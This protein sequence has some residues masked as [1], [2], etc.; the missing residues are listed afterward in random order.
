MEIDYKLSLDIE[1]LQ[2]LDHHSILNILNVVVYELVVLSERLGSVE[3]MDLLLDQVQ[4]AAVLITEGNTPGEFSHYLN[5]LKDA[6]LDTV[7]KLAEDRKIDDTSFIKDSFFNLR[8]IFDILDLRMKELN[9]RKAHPLAWEY[10]EVSTLNDNMLQVFEA[11]SRNSKGRYGFVYDVSHKTAN[12]YLVTLKII[13]SDPLRILMPPVFQDVVRDL[14]ANSRKYTPIGGVLDIEI[15][16]NEQMF[17]FRVTD[18]GV[19]IPAEDIP[20]VIKFGYRGSN[21]L[22]KRTMG[23]GFGLTKAYYMVHLFGG[24]MWIDSPVEDGMGTSIR[25]QIPVPKSDLNG[26]NSFSTLGIRC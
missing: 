1:Q 21:V 11:I 13:S 20:D 14:A 19:G 5:E 18:T 15:N 26:T 3:E 25:V 6:I 9:H 8:S 10:M 22:D 23:G 24:K 17:S 16:Q 2:V 12:D 4:K 7:Q